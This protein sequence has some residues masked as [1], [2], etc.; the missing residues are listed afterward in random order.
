[1]HISLF[2]N[3][4]YIKTSYYSSLTNFG[5]KKRTDRIDSF[6]PS[7]ENSKYKK[8]QQFIT[9]DKKEEIKKLRTAGKKNKEIA[10]ILGIPEYTVASFVST[11]TDIQK[12][13][14]NTPVVTEELIKKVAEARERG[15]AAAETC[16]NL[17]IEQ[18]I[19]D[20]CV[21]KGNLKRKIQK[22]MTPEK[23]EAIKKMR[24]E[25]KSNQE[26]ANILGIPKSSVERAVSDSPDIPKINLTKYEVTD[27][28][29]EEIAKARAN[30]EKSKQTCDRLNITRKHYQ[31]CVTKGNLAKIHQVYITLEKKLMIKKLKDEGKKIKE[32]ADKL[33]LPY[34]V[35]KYTLA[36]LSDIP[37]NRSMVTEE[38][39]NEVAKAREKGEAQR[40]TC[41]RLSISSDIYQA[42]VKKG[43]LPRKKQKYMYPEKTE[44]IKKLRAEGKSNQE[45][46]D[47]LE[48]PK[49]CVA[50][51]VSNSPDI[52]KRVVITQLVTDELIKQVAQARER[53]ELSRETCTNLGINKRTYDTCVSRGNMTKRTQ[54]IIT[55][56]KK[57]LILQMH[58]EGKTHK[59][60]SDELNI[61]AD[62][63][64]NTIYRTSKKPISA[65]TD[66][67][68]VQEV[69]PIIAENQEK[70]PIQ[71]E[72]IKKAD[73]PLSEIEQKILEH[74]R[75]TINGF[76]S[77]KKFCRENNISTAKYNSVVRENI[78]KEEREKIRQQ[79]YK[80]HTTFNQPTSSQISSSSS[81]TFY[82]DDNIFVSSLE[83]INTYCLQVKEEITDIMD[84]PVASESDAEEKVQTFKDIKNEVSVK[85]RNYPENS[86]EY[87]ILQDLIS[88]LDKK[89]TIASKQIEKFNRIKGS[90][91]LPNVTWLNEEDFE[92]K[93]F[94]Q[95]KILN[96]SLIE[97]CEQ[98]EIDDA[99]NRLKE[100]Y[101][102]DCVIWVEDYDTTNT[103]N[104]NEQKYTLYGRFYESQNGKK[105]GQCGTR[106]KFVIEFFSDRKH[107]YKTF[108][109]ALI[110]NKY[111]IAL[112]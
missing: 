73:K 51:L 111:K 23:R 40:D 93:L 79:K 9:P 32:I 109:D 31:K 35:V 92:R 67:K 7:A 100:A 63:V 106:K 44:A 71:N 110:E 28:L 38:L 2:N 54:K 26:I 99:N 43:N 5:G 14:I 96:V 89:I 21:K 42:C 55:P 6:S 12:R 95:Q 80:T 62:I 88:Q 8:K 18:H 84:R 53:G 65:I 98:S 87:K 48:I 20:S 30:G 41:Q 60:I 33:E 107:A 78:S 46:A 10:D 112:N 94:S 1:M 25:G 56:E 15:E 49:H 101:P 34:D 81:K 3:F 47:I 27:E 61:S 103:N 97:H 68:P 86:K 16:K 82:N 75:N 102:E 108:I 77:I 64:A 90:S 59:Q 70:T 57:A 66:N 13:N 76:G 85:I 11:S 83:K 29:I 50:Y 58:A 52:P 72:K 74:F 39:I 37:N 45:I 36:H 91:S 105:Y 22:F 4:S 69:Q 19:Y 104:P 24:A 17:E